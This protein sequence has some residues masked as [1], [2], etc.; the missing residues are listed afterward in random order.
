MRALKLPA[1]FDPFPNMTAEEKA[2]QEKAVRDVQAMLVA[3]SPEDVADVIEAEL[4]LDGVRV[5]RKYLP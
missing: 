2:A 4:A 1:G 5:R 3:H